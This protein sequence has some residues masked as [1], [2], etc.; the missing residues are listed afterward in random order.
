MKDRANALND[1]Y[2]VRPLTSFAERLIYNQIPNQ[3]FFQAVGQRSS[4]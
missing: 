1:H 3:S 2:V 4:L